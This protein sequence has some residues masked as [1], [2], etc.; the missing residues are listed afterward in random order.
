M[1]LRKLVCIRPYL[2][3]S[4]SVSSSFRWIVIFE[5]FS[6]QL[7]N[8]LA[9]RSLELIVAGICLLIYSYFGASFLKLL[10][11]LHLFRPLS[12]FCVD[13]IGCCPIAALPTIGLERVFAKA[14]IVTGLHFPWFLSWEVL[15]CFYVWLLQAQFS[16]PIGA[17]DLF[18]VRVL[19]SFWYKLITGKDFR[20]VPRINWIIS[21][22]QG[23]KCQ[24]LKKFHEGVHPRFTPMMTREIIRSTRW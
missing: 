15:P 19:L 23:E 7:E 6:G 3:L 8:R 2:P 4:N 18:L 9:I 11:F 10:S 5:G 1:E 21:Y 17:H 20:P 12:S 24:D 16:F 22:L 14:M 13:L